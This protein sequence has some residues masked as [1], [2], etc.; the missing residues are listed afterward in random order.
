[1][2]VVGEGVLAGSGLS[3]VGGP[4]RAK[5]IQASVALNR[6]R[7]TD[8]RSWVVACE[9]TLTSLHS[10]KTAR[11]FDSA[12]SDL[13]SGARAPTRGFLKQAALFATPPVGAE[14]RAR[15]RA[16]SWW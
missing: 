9:D 13:N 2:H 14:R 7:R 8:C 12:H 3:L 1:L 15:K 16:S 11:A 10:I 4:R 6:R 5:W